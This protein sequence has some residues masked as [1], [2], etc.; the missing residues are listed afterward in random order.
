LQGLHVF[1]QKAAANCRGFMFFYRRLL[2]IAGAS[3]FFTEGCCK[4]QGLS[5]FVQKALV[6]NVEQTFFFTERLEI[7]F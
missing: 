3:C 2:Q 6:L 7:F 1:L 4:L 5:V